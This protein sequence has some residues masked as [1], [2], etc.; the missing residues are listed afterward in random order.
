MKAEAQ[1]KL[2]KERD[3]YKTTTHSCSLNINPKQVERES[4]RG[5]R[6]R[7]FVYSTQPVVVGVSPFFSRNII[8]LSHGLDRVSG[9]YF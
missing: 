9:R 6:E 2:M 4:K 1:R 8:M 5:E 3:P 7:F